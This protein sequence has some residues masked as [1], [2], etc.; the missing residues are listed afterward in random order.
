[1]SNAKERVSITSFLTIR[2]LSSGLLNAAMG[3]PITAK[4]ALRILSKLCKLMSTTP[5][6]IVESAKNDF[7]GFQDRLEDMVTKAWLRRMP[8]TPAM[9][10]CGYQ[11]SA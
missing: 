4:A 8:S 2:R 10:R 11:F 7:A 5:K 1:M 9:A 3:S 6:K